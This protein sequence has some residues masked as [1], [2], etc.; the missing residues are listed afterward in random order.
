MY[1]TTR[2][3]SYKPIR[4]SHYTVPLNITITNTFETINTPPYSP[5]FRQS[6]WNYL[7]TTTITYHCNYLSTI[8]MTQLTTTRETRNSTIHNITVPDDTVRL[9]RRTL[10]SAPHSTVDEDDNYAGI[11]ISDSKILSSSQ[12]VDTT[13]LRGDANSSNTTM[14]TMIMDIS[15]APT[16]TIISTLPAYINRNSWTTSIAV[17]AVMT[18]R[19]LR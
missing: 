4:L 11:A 18:R 6:H 10:K 12:V 13:G 8:I 17:T 9:R 1:T 3:S 5:R 7:Y 15:L 19:G 16:S 14:T 2:K